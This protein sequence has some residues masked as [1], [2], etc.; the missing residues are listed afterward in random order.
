M[1]SKKAIIVCSNAGLDYFSY[2]KDIEIFR[3][4]IH[5]SN[6]DTYEDFVDMKAKTFYE[7]IAK[8]PNDVPKTSYVAPGRMLEIF[9][10]Y[11]KKG[12]DEAIVITISSK[13]SGLYEAVIRTAE[14]Q[15]KLKV[16]VFDSKSLAYIEAHMALEAHRLA[17]EGKTTKEIITYLEKI[18]DN[19]QWYFTVETLLYLV[20]NGRLSSFKGLMGTLL[21]LKPVMEISKEGKVENLEKIRSFSKS[22]DKVLNKY[23]EETKDKNVLTYIS[24]AHNDEAANYLI[25]QILEV[26]PDRVIKSSYLTPVVGA[27]TGPKSIG[28][29][30][31]LL[32]NLK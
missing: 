23:L 4:V 19:N 30:Y 1:A 24:H 15:S 8:N 25:K 29:G 31:L 32:D 16:T 10:D 11:A 26:Y 2:P 18:R 17:E 5:F 7:R 13:L 21:K 27:H 28:L 20:K 22:L 3:S 6:D 12:Y 9:E 14:E